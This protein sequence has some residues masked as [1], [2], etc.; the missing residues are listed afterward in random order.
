MSEK[1]KATIFPR[2]ANGGLSCSNAG[3]KWGQGQESGRCGQAGRTRRG[4]CKECVQPWPRLE[5]AALWYVWLEGQGPRREQ[6]E[7]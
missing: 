7:T 3:R 1:L 2:I 4:P 6:W 5:Q